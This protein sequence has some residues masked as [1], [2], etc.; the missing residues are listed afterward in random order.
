MSDNAPPTSA[1]DTPS[2][3]VP[4]GTKSKKL[5]LLGLIFVIA[6]IGTEPF[7]LSLSLTAGVI[8]VLLAVMS[9]YV[10]ILGYWERN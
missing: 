2:T 5:M 7:F 4:W 9:V 6:S 1:A 10:A 3:A 8:S